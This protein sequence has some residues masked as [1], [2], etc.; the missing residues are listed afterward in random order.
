MRIV[1]DIKQSIRALTRNVKLTATTTLLLALG[2]GVN[3]AVFEFASATIWKRLAVTR[4]TS[5]VLVRSAGA[6]GVPKAIPLVAYKRLKETIGA[7]A[8][9]SA[10][11]GGLAQV[12]FA[13][14]SYLVS[15]LTTDQSLLDVLEAKA[16]VGSLFK[17]DSDSSD[18]LISERFWRRHLDANGEI[19]GTPIMI[20][21]VRLRIRGIVANSFNGPVAG[22]PPDVILS[23]NAMPI[24]GHLSVG[25]FDRFPVSIIGRLKGTTSLTSIKERLNAVWPEVV[26][27]TVPP[28]SNLDRW[29]TA[30]G[31]KII[32]DEGL[33]GVNRLRDVL[34]VPIKITALFAICLLLS[35]LGTLAMIVLARCIGRHSELATRAALGA[36]Y[37][38]LLQ[39][40]LI[41]WFLFS[42]P[43]IALSLVVGRSLAYLGTQFLPA[44]NLPRSI[45]FPIFGLP[46]AISTAASLALVLL[47][48][49][50]SV[51][52][53][54]FRRKLTLASS[55]SI[56]SGMGLRS[57]FLG[58][59]V[60]TG[61]FLLLLS[62][63]F[64]S[65]IWSLSKQDIGIG[66]ENLHAYFFSAKRGTQ[67]VTTFAYFRDLLDSVRRQPG[68]QDATLL[69]GILFLPP[70]G[71]AIMLGPSDADIPT[72]PARLHCVWPGFFQTVKAPHLS[73]RDFN[74]FDDKGHPTVGIVSAGLAAKLS[75]S[76]KVGGLGSIR[77]SGRQMNWVANVVGVVGNIKHGS[78][79]EAA[80]SDL[81]V[82][83]QQRWT[84]QTFLNEST[85]LVRSS[86][87]GEDIRRQIEKLGHQVIFKDASIT[88]LLDGTVSAERLLAFLTLVLGVI[89][90][91]VASLGAFGLGE[92]II[93]SQSKEFGIR[94]A[95]GANGRS[96]VWVISRRLALTVALGVISGALA[97]LLAI[98]I[99]ST[100]LRTASNAACASCGATP[101]PTS[102]L[103]SYLFQMNIAGEYLIAG[104]A[105]FLL[106]FMLVMALAAA[107][108]KVF[109][110]DP[111]DALRSE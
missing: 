10:W 86:A 46:A 37:P 67:P 6:D 42:L 5:L 61:M 40:V 69:D 72:V 52:S 26:A 15:R 14:E 57:A 25:S 93:S 111:M 74:D 47:V 84:P 59:Q 33:Y 50:L 12:D 96:I 9:L 39:I 102:I 83:C 43:G 34:A 87:S 90:V 19:I 58:V 4:P 106:V 23:L 8:D 44:S 105:A 22:F 53:F 3:S 60:A 109:T 70:G 80:G 24:V 49:G 78:P 28:Q 98:R 79:R 35:T 62:G 110:S 104:V 94:R 66:R 36:R 82:P 54:L 1:S 65:T 32:V 91:A 17:D 97:G 21:G 71:T 107:A 20:D 99:D 89:A 45:D 29:R 51:T 41:E 2:I 75:D 85:L 30:T 92:I 88:S 108:R 38:A 101:P 73:G 68:V 77:I 63:M 76:G 55:R 103:G 48:S 81:Y 16:I 18:A 31:L 13:G 95:L 7:G 56:A 27:S 64:V 100:W 11:D